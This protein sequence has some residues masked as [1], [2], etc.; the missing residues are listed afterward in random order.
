MSFGLIH[1]K[2]RL[3]KKQRKTLNEIITLECCSFNFIIILGSS[4][5][6]AI[7]NLNICSLYLLM[8]S[9]RADWCSSRDVRSSANKIQNALKSLTQR[10]KSTSTRISAWENW[11]EPVTVSPLPAPWN[12]H[13]LCKWLWWWSAWAKSWSLTKSLLLVWLQF[14]P[15]G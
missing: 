10:T 9:S 11:N 12:L 3:T 1:C 8:M 15:C 6:L 5:L 4:F 7:S 13:R 2:L 14:S